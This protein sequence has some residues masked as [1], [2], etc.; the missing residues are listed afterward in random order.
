M[1]LT[2]RAALILPLAALAIPVLIRPARAACRPVD[3][4]VGISFT[5]KDGS[6]GVARREGDGIVF[7][8]YV[9]NRGAWLDRRRVR[10]GVFEISRVVEE[11]EE[12]VVGNSAPDYAWTFSRKLIDPADG[13]TWSGRVKEVVEVTISDEKG[14]VER[15]R[16]SW[17]ASYRCFDPREVTLSGCSYRVLTVEASFSGENGDRSQRWVYFTDLG[18]GLETRRDGRSNGLTA[19]GPV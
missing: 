10:N 9:T 3:L 19:L 8:D 5:R 4:V 18:L 17:S 13:A 15:Q 1:T 12:P 6:R 2:R 7:I 16:T 11:S 14:T